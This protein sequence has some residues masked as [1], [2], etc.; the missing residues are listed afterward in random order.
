MITI[1]DFGFAAKYPFVG[2]LGRG[3]G[4]RYYV[5]PEMMKKKKYDYKIDV[6]SSTVLVFVLLCGKLP[7][8]G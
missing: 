8:N 4:T 7:Y 6:W 1:A 2:D 5:A 3:A